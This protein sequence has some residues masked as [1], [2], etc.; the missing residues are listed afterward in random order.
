MSKEQTSILRKEINETKL[1]IEEEL[2]FKLSD[3]DRQTSAFTNAKF[4]ELKKKMED[5]ARSPRMK[6]SG[7]SS[8]GKAEK[9]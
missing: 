9:N 5:L 8:P 4:N 6:M 3:L 1:L 7:I 2:T